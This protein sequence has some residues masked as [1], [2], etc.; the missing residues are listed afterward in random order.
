MK[1][2]SQIVFLVLIS[3]LLV[4][5]G[6]LTVFCPQTSP[7]Q[8]DLWENR[9]LA[10]TPDFT[11]ASLFDGSL[12]TQI[13]AYLSDHLY[14][15]T[16]LLRADVRL[17]EWIGC[18]SVNGV[19][20]SDGVLLP[21]NGYFDEASLSETKAAARTAS[22]IAAIRDAT[23][24]NGGILLYVALPTQRTVFSEYY[25]SYMNSDAVRINRQL[26]ALQPALSAQNI[27]TFYFEDSVRQSESAVFELYS[28]IDHHFTLKGAYLCCE[29][30]ITRLNGLGCN[31][32]SL[33][34]DITFEAL[35]NPM[36]GTYNRKLYGCS[37]VSDS[38]LIYRTAQAVPYERSDN[39]D[40]TDTPLIV[41]PEDSSSFVQYSAYMGG[42]KAE[43]VIRTNRTY[44]KKL[45]IVGDSFTNAMETMLY[46]SFDEMRSLDFRYYSE[47]TLS[48]YIADYQPDVVLIVRDC[49]VCLNED[50]NGNLQ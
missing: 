34:Q 24:A 10:D 19:L 15:R 2:T 22:Q 43:T 3:A 7:K 39:G 45:L 48:E 40:E 5:L 28:P 14:A 29:A 16:S 6:V 44:L 21:D 46:L 11:A 32:P 20:E 47:K 12:S 9:N 17:Q 49:S 13:E 38:L 37:G 25:P 23:E 8:Y 30:V 1:K 41:L 36:L 27:E 18:P 33:P 31:I 26:A 42:D 50:G 4:V 35:P